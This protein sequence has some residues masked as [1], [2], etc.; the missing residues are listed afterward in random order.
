MSIFQKMQ[1]KRNRE[2]IRKAERM[3]G[4]TMQAELS[5]T[6]VRVEILVQDAEKTTFLVEYANGEKKE[7]TM[8]N[9]SVRFQELG[10]YIG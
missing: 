9:T 5:M 8:E 6:I 1:E 4:F 2:C 10:Q 7:E 3:Q